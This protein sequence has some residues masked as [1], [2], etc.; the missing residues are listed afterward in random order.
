M[1]TIN[2]KINPFQFGALGLM[3][4]NALFVGFGIIITITNSKQDAWI[5][6]IL[7]LLI[8][9]V[10]IGMILYIMNYKPDKNI[11]E[12]NRYIFGT[13]MGNI[14][15]F[16]IVCSVLFMLSLVIWTSTY[17]CLTQYLTKVP[18]FYLAALFILTASYAAIKGIETIARTNEIIVFV[19]IIIISI[20][21]FSLY[22]QFHFV[23]LKP[24]LVNG[25]TPLIKHSFMAISYSFPPLITL[26]IIP[27]NDIVN[28]KKYG[29]FFL[30]GFLLS[31]VFMAVTFYLIV[32]VVTIGVAELFRYPVY[33]VQYKIDVAGFFQGMENFLALHWLFNTFV[34]MMMCIYYINRY[35]KDLFKVKKEK[36]LNIF[37]IVI[38]IAIAYGSSYLFED[39]VMGVQFMKNKYPYYFALPLILLL[40]CI[41]IGIF[42]KKIIDKK[43]AYDE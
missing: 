36:K 40:L 38:G 24:I 43:K 25:V 12:K 29:R 19:A 6:M 37:T 15:N 34:M 39:S 7:A 27:K 18:Y 42:V 16:V 33:F 2:N 21:W 10:P 23:Q 28:N 11:L 22:E 41:M 26:M 8:A 14:I 17:F 9:L 20:V 1:E 32:G 4:G 31:I 35:V 3:L 30:L 13:I 5:T